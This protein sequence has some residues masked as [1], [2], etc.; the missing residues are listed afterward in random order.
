MFESCLGQEN[1]NEKPRVTSATVSPSE[2][3]LNGIV[4]SSAAVKQAPLDGRGG[5]AS[6][7]ARAIHC[8]EP[9]DRSEPDKQASGNCS[10]EEQM[11]LSE[12]GQRELAT[13]SDCSA[14]AVCST[15]GIEGAR[16]EGG[17][18]ASWSSSEE[19][20]GSD[21]SGSSGMT[22]VKCTLENL[23]YEETDGNDIQELDEINQDV[24][25]RMEEGPIVARDLLEEEC[26]DSIQECSRCEGIYKLNEELM[27]ERCGV[28]LEDECERS[29]LEEGAMEEWI[30]SSDDENESDEVSGGALDVS[31]TKDSDFRY[32]SPAG[33][34]GSSV[35]AEKNDGDRDVERSIVF[36]PGVDPMWTSEIC[37]V[38]GH[39]GLDDMDGTIPVSYTHLTLPTIYSV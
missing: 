10:M 36:D 24:V 25:V 18:S 12:P 19:I 22:A 15:F 20:S 34:I 7:S 29:S 16:S 21:V 13:S 8:Q 23:L 35:L 39:I 9:G 3:R 27:R 6:M 28:I 17:W 38:H 5:A 14:G 2:A 11:V 32:V 31:R 37:V 33:V 1:V 30:F 4:V 26:R